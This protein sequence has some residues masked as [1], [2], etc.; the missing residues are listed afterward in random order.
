M[1]L[2]ICLESTPATSLKMD[3][4]VQSEQN[5]ER[6][7]VSEKS[8]EQNHCAVNAGSQASTNVLSAVNI[9]SI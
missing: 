9:H 2:L 7:N 4:L 3:I 6:Q 8:K 5:T 1:S